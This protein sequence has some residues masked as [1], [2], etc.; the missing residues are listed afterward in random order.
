[1]NS[2]DPED[3]GLRCNTGNSTAKAIEENEESND[4][5]PGKKSDG[6]VELELVR[7]NTDEE[8]DSSGLELSNAGSVADK[9]YV[10]GSTDSS[11]EAEIG[12]GS[13]GFVPEKR[14]RDE[15]CFGQAKKRKG[16]EVI[17]VLEAGTSS[18]SSEQKNLRVRKNKKKKDG[19]RSWT[20]AITAYIAKNPITSYPSTLKVSIKTNL[21]LSKLF[22]IQ[23]GRTKGSYYSKSSENRGI[24]AIIL[25]FTKMG[26]VL[27][28]LARA[29]HCPAIPKTTLH[30]DT[31]RAYT[32]AS[33]YFAT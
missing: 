2:E 22:V 17:P 12:T 5:D 3:L 27:F 14:K 25:K 24:S 18:L 20:S 26:R 23:R 21:I 6:Q 9:D 29:Y 32:C 19:K 33:I 1:M 11:N 31:A 28:C 10:P 4:F 15:E 7:E 16:E 13:R 8:S 30:A